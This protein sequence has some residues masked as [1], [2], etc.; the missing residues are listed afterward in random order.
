MKDGELEDF[1]SL[2]IQ[3]TVLTVWFEF[4]YTYLVIDILW[5][6][7]KWKKIEAVISPEELEL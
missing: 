3:K 7:S 1:I 5:K 6:T 4:E 2:T